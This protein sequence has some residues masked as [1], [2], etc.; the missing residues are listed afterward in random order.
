MGERIAFQRPDGQTC[1]GY[2]AT[3]AGGGAGAPGIVVVE[4][5]W[6]VTPQI[7]Q[8]ADDLAARGYRALVPDLYRGRTAAVG[9]EANHLM[10]GLDFGDAAT[11]DVRG[12][13]LELKKNGAKVAVLGFCMGGA[14]S[15]LAG[16]YVREADAV[17]PFYGFPPPEAGDPGRIPVPVLAHAARHDEFFEPD[18]VEAFEE[19]LRAGGVPHELHWYDAGHGFTNPMPVGEAGL[20]HYDEAAANQAWDRTYAFLDRVLK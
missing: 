15:V 7:V 8:V 1:P 3:P 11:Q 17:V 9:D 19:K 6:G 14:I 16:M 13:V 5:W 18:A 4:E 10:E 2:L 12:A 20:G